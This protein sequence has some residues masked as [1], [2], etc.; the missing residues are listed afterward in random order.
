MDAIETKI[1]LCF[2]E[3]QKRNKKH[4]N[5]FIIVINKIE[6]SIIKLELSKKTWE[7]LF[8]SITSQTAFR[9]LRH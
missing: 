3:P 4:T 5:N 8:A 1:N 2:R 9:C 7:C 6:D